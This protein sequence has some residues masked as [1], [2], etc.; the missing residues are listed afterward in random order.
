[1]NKITFGNHEL[2]VTSVYP[3]RYANG[4]VVLRVECDESVTSEAPMKAL[5]DN[6][7]DILYYEFNEDTQ[8]YEL[9]ITYEG[10]TTGDYTSAYNG[11]YS[12]EIR[13]EDAVTEQVAMNTADIEYLM[14]MVD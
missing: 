2:A 5:K 8:K 12:C 7:E 9:K 4:K 14:L 6:T 1:M 11:V 3:F 10:Y 13:Q